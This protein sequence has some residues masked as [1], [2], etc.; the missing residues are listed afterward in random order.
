MEDHRKTKRKAKLTYIVVITLIVLLS[1]VVYM[2]TQ[3][4]T[5]ERLFFKDDSLKD[6]SGSRIIGLYYLLR[7]YKVDFGTWPPSETWKRDLEPYAGPHDKFNDA[8]GNQIQ[9]VNMTQDG[10]QIVK[11][12]SFGKNGIDE[13]GLNDD[14]VLDVL[15]SEKEGA[16][17]RTGVQ[18]R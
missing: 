5:I 6:A 2:E 10:K 12:Y 7:L 15:E 16:D 1:I 4:L 3:H 8:W 14:Y 11:L 17:L 13:N 9:Y 18:V